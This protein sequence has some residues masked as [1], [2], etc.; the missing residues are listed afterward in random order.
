[1]YI[2]YKKYLNEIVGTAIGV[3]AGMRLANRH[4]RKKQEKLQGKANQAIQKTNEKM[5]MPNNTPIQPQNPNT[6]Q[7]M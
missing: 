6:Q 4:A 5:G 7:Q 2:K 1:M 3:Y